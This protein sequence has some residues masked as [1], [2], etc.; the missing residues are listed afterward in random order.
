MNS[1]TRQAMPP[2]TTLIDYNKDV[3]NAPEVY[4]TIPLTS[5]TQGRHLLT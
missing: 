3:K 2:T 1:H 4:Y 5:S